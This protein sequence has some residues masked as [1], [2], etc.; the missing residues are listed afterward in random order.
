M[1]GAPRDW[2]FGND[3]NDLDFY[4]CST[5]N[6]MTRTKWQLEKVGFNG[7]EHTQTPMQ[8]GLYQ[9]M[10]GLVRIWECCVDGIKVQLIQ[11]SGPKHR[12]KVVDNTDV[13]ICKAYY[14]ANGQI[15][16]HNDCKLTFASGVMFLK[17][18]YCWSDKHAVKMMERF[19]KE[20]TCGTK[21]SAIKR[22]LVGALE[23][24]GE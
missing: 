9:S 20:F 12:W 16:L 5:A 7:V 8:S 23:S 11:L 22:I 2:Y 3:A 13:S 15:K 1:V 19:G 10:E 4:F 17:D 24:Y 18:G 14:L 6:T 21:D